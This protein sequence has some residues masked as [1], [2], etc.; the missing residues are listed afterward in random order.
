MALVAPHRNDALATPSQAPAEV[1]GDSHGPTWAY[2]VVVV[3]GIL[4]MDVVGGAS[5]AV[6]VTGVATLPFLYLFSRPRPP[7]AAALLR[8][9]IDM[10][11]LLVGALLYAAVVGLFRV[12]FTVF[13]DND[14][15]LFMSFAAGLLVGVV[16]P[17]HYT[18]RTRGRSLASLGL[19]L[20][21]LRTTL[22]LALVFA[23]VQFS[24]TLWG[25]DLPVA[26]GWVPLLGMALTVGVFESI[27]FRG[28]VQGRL[29]SSFGVIPAVFGAA[30]LYAIYHVGYGMGATE[31][32]FLF[33][34]GIVYALA[35]QTVGN[36]LVLWPL[37]TPLGSFYA[38]LDSGDLVGRLPWASL[39]GFADVLA[40][41]VT[42]VWWAR[43]Y[44]RKHRVHD[45]AGV[46]PG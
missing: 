25:Y 20:G 31:T 9:D 13:D 1:S 40:L 44:E 45:I 7:E 11:D 38:Q 33:G 43:R 24:I 39:F 41:F 42:A 4:L 28:F 14:G 8:R 21:G 18:V 15:L 17:I 30:A 35:Y 27:F 37:L 26:K 36:V 12:A 29:E 19:S 10:N 3:L 2:A 5:Y 46:S 32:V 16:G 23:A 6:V 22:G 34:L